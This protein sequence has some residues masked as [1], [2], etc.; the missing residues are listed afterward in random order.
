MQRFDKF[1]NE[2]NGTTTTTEPPKTNPAPTA[3]NGAASTSATPDPKRS[4]GSESALS[5]LEDAAPPKKKAKKSKTTEDED[6]AFAR[7]L[8]AEENARS[9]RA[10]RGGNTRKKAPLPK[11]KATKKKS[12]N[13]VKD[14]DD[15]DIASGSDKEKKSPSRKGGFHVRPPS[16][17][18]NN[19]LTPQ[20][21]AN[22]A[23]TPGPL[24]TNG[25]LPRALRPPQRI[26]AL[27]PADG[28]KD[29]G[30]REGARP[31]GPQRQ[32]ADPLRR[33]HARCLQERPRPHV[34]HEQ[35]PQPE[36][37]RRR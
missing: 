6:A 37:L 7:K 31:A 18:H 9:G 28:E 36:S 22:S 23:N 15:S 8:Q 17:T 29:L 32:A 34:H 2:V 20:T 35:D 10:T 11:K 30:V 13:R 25:A 19:P 27:A 26:A 14:E 4:P 33:R 12:S 21:H 24:E 3:A 5:E 1:N 16:F